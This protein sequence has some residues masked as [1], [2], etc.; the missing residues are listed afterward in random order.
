V[1][2]VDE[3]AANLTLP[4]V[5]DLHKYRL[6]IGAPTFENVEVGIKRW[7]MS[8]HGVDAEVSQFADYVYV[9]TREP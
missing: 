9:K 4:P 5:D 6:N 3:R 8:I 1:F 7:K 2:Y